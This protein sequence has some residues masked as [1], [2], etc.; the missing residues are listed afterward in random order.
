MEAAE[1]PKDQVDGFLGTPGNNIYISLD[2][3]SPERPPTRRG[4]FLVRFHDRGAQFS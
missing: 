1:Q 2:D 3:D 4:L